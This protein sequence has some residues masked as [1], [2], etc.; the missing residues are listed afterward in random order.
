MEDRY[1]IVEILRQTP[2]I[3]DNCQ[4]AIFLRNHDELTLEMVTDEERD[5]MYRMYAQ[6]A[7]HARSTWASAAGLRRCSTNDVDRIEL[8][9]ALL[10]SMPGTPIIY[11]GDEIGMGDNIYLGRPQRRAHADAMEHRSQRRLFAHGPAAALSAGHHGSDLRLS[12]SK[13]RGAESRSILATQLDEAS[14]GRAAPA[15]GSSVAA[16]STLSVR[17]TA[18][19]SRT[20]ATFRDEIVLCVANLA[21]TAQSVELDLSAYK[22]RVPVELLGRNAFPPI[23]D[24]PYFLTLPAHAFFWL[25]LSDRAS[26]PD[27]A[28]RAHAGNGAARARHAD[29]ACNLAS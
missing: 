26:P 1:P 27:V 10:L 19:Y 8:M 13:R 15:S 22:G 21:Q 20:S 7:A 11:Y 14:A 17:V 2:D 6:R 18:R 9:N 25:L 23:G 3:P 5:Y 24:L 12:G 4:W 28:H 29:G 16:P